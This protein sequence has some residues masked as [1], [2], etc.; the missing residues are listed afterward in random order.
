MSSRRWDR[1]VQAQ[2]VQ[3]AQTKTRATAAPTTRSH[4]R[5]DGV[6]GKEASCLSKSL[7]FM[8]GSTVSP[9]GTPRC[10]AAFLFYMHFF[11]D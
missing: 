5:S 3:M 1:S 7:A 9:E 4:S 6:S 10:G 11:H 2:K 8:A